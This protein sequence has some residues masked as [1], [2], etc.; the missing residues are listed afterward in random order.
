MDEQD[1]PGQTEAQKGSLQGWKQGQVSWEE[2]RDIIHAAGDQVRKAKAMSELNLARGIKGNKKRLYRYVSD[3][4]KARENVG[5]LWKDRAD[6]VT[7]NMEKAEVLNDTFVSVF[8]C[9]CSSH[10]AQVTEDRGRDWENAEL[11]TLREDQVRDHL[12]NLK[13]YKSMG[14]DETLPRVMRELVDEVAKPLS[15]I[16][17]KSW[18]SGEV[19]SN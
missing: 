13:V 16:F 17:Q 11:S 6:L 5:P 3:N 2:Y 9:K 12:R 4:R 18:Q 19:P 8:T 7:R 14:P 15:I 1:A 10:T